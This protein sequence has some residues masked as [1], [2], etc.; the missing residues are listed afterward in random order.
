MALEVRY[1]GTSSNNLVRGIDLNQIDIFNNGFL[2]DFNRASQNVALTGNAFCT[3]A[4]NAGCQALT[5]LR[6]TGA[7]VTPGAGRILV[8]AAGTGF[9]GGLPLTTLTSNIQNGTPADLAFNII[10]QGFNN[11]ATLNNPTGTPFVNFLA[12]PNTGVVDLL[13]NDARFRYNS[14]QV[15]LRRRFAQGLFFQANYTFSKNLTNAQGTAQSQFEPFL[16]NNN[17]ELDYARADSDQTH[18]FNFNGAYQLPFGKGKTFLNQGGIVDRIFGGFEF[19]G[20]VQYGTGAPITFTDVR[21]TLNRDGRSGRQTAVSSLTREQLQSLVGIFERTDA[22]G[23]NRIYFID[24]SIIDPATGRA[25]NGFGSARFEGQ[26]FSN[27][28]PGQ[29]GSLARAVIDGPRNFNVNAALL[30][31]IRITETT[32]FQIRVEAF[33]LFNN[34]NFFNNTQFADVNSSVF[35]QIQSAGAARSI[36]FAGRFEF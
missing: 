33:N 25:S 31:N 9:V 36:Q 6:Q 10:Q 34:V 5:I 19:S 2:A 28:N 30:K 11:S 32:R 20:L 26:A 8:G 27:N 12:N 13:L 21:G 16:D 17:R 35:G 18:T 22:S 14:L 7:G 15:E 3:T 23:V 1:V 4:Q 29:T 24:P